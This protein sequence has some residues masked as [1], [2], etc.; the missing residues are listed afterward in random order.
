MYI[1]YFWHEELINY[2]L[3]QDLSVKMP[4]VSMNYRLI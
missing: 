2:L 1:I 3:W 4:L